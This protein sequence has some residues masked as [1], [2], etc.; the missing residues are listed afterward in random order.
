MKKYLLTLVILWSVFSFIPRS[1]ESQQALIPEWRLIGIPVNFELWAV[2][3]IDVN[4]G[5][6]VGDGGSIVHTSNGGL[7]WERQSLD[8]DTLK[9]RAVYFI[10]DLVGWVAGKNGALFKTTDGGNTW[11]D[12]N[13]DGILVEKDDENIRD[14]TSIDFVGENTGWIGTTFPEIPPFE[15]YILHTT[16]GGDSWV[17]LPLP[18]TLGIMDI[19]FFF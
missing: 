18:N 17:K 10:N 12:K 6:A 3:F 4:K 15:P 16:D 13:P 9:L 11:L 5:W 7:T 2:D 19:D 14:I 8:A 1:A